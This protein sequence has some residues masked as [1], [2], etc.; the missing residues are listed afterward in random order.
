M[1]YGDTGSAAGPGATSSDWLG[2]VS[3]PNER[4]SRTPG[5]AVDWCGRRFPEAAS[6]CFNIQK[7][8][9]SRSVCMLAGTDLSCS[10]RMSNFACSLGLPKM[11]KYT[12]IL[13]RQP[14]D[15]GTRESGLNVL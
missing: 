7:H 4:L 12:R 2:L 15:K 1:G 9:T 11:L 10:G 6:P 8:S 5:E 13:P 3:E 14:V